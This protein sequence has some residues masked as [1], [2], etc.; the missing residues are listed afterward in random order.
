MPVNNQPV[1]IKP[2]A[3]FIGGLWTESTPLNF[4]EN[5]VEYTQNFVYN[6]DG[7]IERRLG[8]S[9]T[10]DINR[11]LVEGKVAHT[12]EWKDAGNSDDLTII[13]VQ[14]GD[15][16]HLYEETGKC[17][18]NYEPLCSY[19]LNDFR[20]NSTV[21][22]DYPVDFA[23]G[24]GK[25]FVAHKAIQPIYITY[26]SGGLC[27]DEED[28]CAVR[29]I[30]IFERDFEGVEDGLLAGQHPTVL[31]DEHR[32]NLYNQGWTDEYIQLHFDEDGTYPANNEVW[33]LG[34]YVDPDDG[35]EK[36][37]VEELH[38][39][40][41]GSSN[42]IGGHFI[43]NVFDTCDVFEEQS[44][45]RVA[46]TQISKNPTTGE[47][48]ERIRLTFTNPHGYSAGDTFEITGS[49]LSMVKP[50]GTE[51][52]HS[53]D[54]VY[55]VGVDGTA[56]HDDMWVSIVFTIPGYVE[57]EDTLKTVSQGEVVLD[58]FGN[59]VPECCS[60]TNRPEVVALYAQRTWHAGVDDPRIGNKIYFSQVLVDDNRIGRS[61]QAADPTN[62]DFN[63]LQKT[64]GG[65]IDIPEIGWIKALETIK[66]ALL[67]FADNGIW[68]ITGGTY[69]YFSADSYSVSKL[70]EVGCI[71]KKSV[72]EAEDSWIYAA[73]R[74]V[75]VITSDHRVQN[76]TEKAIHRRY[77][78]IPQSKKPEIDITY[79][80][81]NKTVHIYHSLDSDVEDWRYC[82]ELIVDHRIEAWY[83]YTFRENLIATTFMTGNDSDRVYDML[84]L[85][86]VADRAKSYFLSNCFFKDWADEANEIDTPAYLLTGAETLGELSVDK[87]IKKISFFMNNE[88][89]TVCKFRGRWDW[90]CNECANKWTDIKSGFDPKTVCDGVYPFKVIRTDYKKLKG[91]GRAFEMEFSTEPEK[92]FKL[93]GWNINYVAR[94]GD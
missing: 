35:K 59:L 64:D 25:L 94:P 3:N 6:P 58:N 33:Q 16:L 91:Y 40:N 11:L 92:P 52:F 81:Y 66:D 89:E 48:I 1:Q 17:K 2:Y 34:L 74:G 46:F 93:Y 80:P 84:Y 4:P 78:D 10:D 70:T 31:T 61:Y 85:V 18:S 68:A 75:Y 60:T 9:V 67:I 19:D 14:A 28:G 21:I 39:S 72:A 87:E 30:Q 20:V 44:D 56:T 88:G 24:Q 32:Y 76:I 47:W 51:T 13:A 79:N 23:S 15:I 42:A 29:T 37:S 5:T 26:N 27:K 82:S 86:D 77:R 45:N 55:T 83:E 65:V 54:G 49:L 57:G 36:W 50:D 63:E 22:G 62:P 69:E 43:R 73:N 8:L 38:K 7:S 90:A 12:H 71:A 53:Y 41:T